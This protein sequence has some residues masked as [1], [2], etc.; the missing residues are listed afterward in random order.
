MHFPAFF[1]NIWPLTGWIVF[2][3]CISC[4]LV[5]CMTFGTSFIEKFTI[6]CFFSWIQFFVL[7]IILINFMVEYCPSGFIILEVVPAFTWCWV[8][9]QYGC[10]L[11]KLFF[12]RAYWCQILIISMRCSLLSSLAGNSC[13]WPFFYRWV[14]YDAWM[15][16][17]INLIRPSSWFELEHSW[18]NLI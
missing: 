2:M 15:F 16:V 4:R 18:I 13:A 9:D 1:S 3:L 11:C 5:I 8:I 17:I 10:I 14:T 12:Y 6:S 7:I